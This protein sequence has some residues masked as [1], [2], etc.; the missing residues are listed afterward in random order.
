MTAILRRELKSCFYSASAYV[1]MLVFL[2]L[3]SV[4]FAVGNLASRSGDLAGL[5][6]NMGYLWMLLTPILTM[7]AYAGERQARTD[8]LLYSS[9]V[10]LTA[11]VIGKYLAGCL[12]L[13]LTVF[14]SLIYA[15]IIALYGTLYPGEALCA[16]LGFILQGCT[17]LA[18]DMYV[19][20]RSH[21][22]LTAAVWALGVNLILWM[23][24]VAAQAV[25]SAV[26]ADILSRFSLYKRALPF[27]QG[28]LSPASICFFL[29]VTALMLFLTV[30]ALDE[31]RWIEG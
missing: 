27:R 6:W 7:R 20:A 25:R 15:V 13:L 30:Q 10:S 18:I 5:L 24:D 21:T 1:Y 4:F 8:V 14:L 3:G 19:S 17:F 29:A 9:P 31:R 16:Y 11:A 26:L 23:T 22:V 12:I 28:Q 2:M